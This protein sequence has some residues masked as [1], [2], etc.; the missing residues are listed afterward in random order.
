MAEFIQQVGAV[1]VGFGIVKLIASLVS[2]IKN[3]V[4]KK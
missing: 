1:V 4:T 2:I 3:E